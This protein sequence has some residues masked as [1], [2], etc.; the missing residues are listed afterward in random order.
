MSAAD[1]SVSVIVPVYHEALR[2]P[3]SLRAMASYFGR[4]AF[5]HEILI[6]V[7]HGTDGTLELALQATAKQANFQVIDNRVHRGKGYAVRSGMLRARGGYV[8]YMDADLSTPLEE[9]G[10]FLSYFEEHPEVHV[11]VGNRQHP[12]SRIERRQ[13][14]LRQ[15]MGQ[16]FNR[17]LRSLAL[18]DIRDTQCGFK[19]F[20]QPAAREIFSRQTID[21]FAFDVEVLLLARA[22]GFGVADL[23][24]RWENSPESKVHIFRDSVRMMWDTLLVRRRVERALREQPRRTG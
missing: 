5:S 19:A 9:I 2:L 17:A 3:L 21:G 22:L 15:N 13:G 11:L 7:E 12:E 16:L 8:F 4:V 20:R 24:V 23:P 1:P 18:V 10:R 6:V 14:V